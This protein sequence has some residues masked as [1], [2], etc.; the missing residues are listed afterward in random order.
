VHYS[1]LVNEYP[2]EAP[3]GA[4]AFITHMR[5]RLGV[6]AATTVFF[7][8]GLGDWLWQVLAGP[9]VGATWGDVGVY[10]RARAGVGHFSQLIFKPG[11][12][13]VALFPMPEACLADPYNL[14]VD[15]GGTVEV[16]LSPSKTLRFDLGDTLT[17]WGGAPPETQW[18]HG[19]QF[20]A[21]V[22]WKF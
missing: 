14:Q 16:N 11:I 22:G 15:I 10:G 9:R 6:D 7:P 13:C 21:G 19:L 8:A 12:V 4:G 5:G 1:A 20:T 3:S 2:N 18:T 17:R